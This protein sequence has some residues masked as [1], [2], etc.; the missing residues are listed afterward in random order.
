MIIFFFGQPGSGKTTLAKWAKDKFGQDG[1]H[2][3]GDMLRKI[4]N[5]TDYS[6]DGRSRNM[7]RAIDI[8]KYEDSKNSMVICSFVA[9]FNWQRR[10]LDANTDVCWVHLFYN[11]YTHDRCKMK[12]MVDS[13]AKPTRLKN[14]LH[15]DT[16]ELS[17]EE[18]QER[19]STF[20][21]NHSQKV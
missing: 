16:G 12:F 4:F 10:Y 18:C 20:F 14:V 6:R 3:D 17:I 19:I 21:M 8:A 9:P 1:V 11:P 13:F 2:L 7:Q 15:L 5:D